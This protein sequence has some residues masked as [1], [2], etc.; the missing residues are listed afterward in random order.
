MVAVAAG[1]RRLYRR[2]RRRARRAVAR[3]AFTRVGMKRGGSMLP[4]RLSKR[5]RITRRRPRISSV[6]GTIAKLIPEKTFQTIYYNAEEVLRTVSFSGPFMNAM[7]DPSTGLSQIM[8]RVNSIYDPCYASLSTLNTTSEMYGFFARYYTH[9]KV[10]S[11]QITITVNQADDLDSNNNQYGFGIFLNETTGLN[12]TPTWVKAQLSPDWRT[13]NFYSKN[14]NVGNIDRSNNKAT[15][16]HRWSIKK[17]M[18]DPKSD[19]LV[20]AMGTN[21]T[22]TMYYMPCICEHSN[23]FFVVG[24][25]KIRPKMEVK[26][27]FNVLFTGRKDL[28]DDTD[29]MPQ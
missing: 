27:R 2:V 7:Y 28:D 22:D 9:Y 21:P 4:A 18:K 26:I 5:R 13:K 25:I 17:D 19:G 24:N 12:S 15:V 8:F 1:R 11:S 14:V 16:N 20:A 6:R 23:T 29:L 3:R 10:Y